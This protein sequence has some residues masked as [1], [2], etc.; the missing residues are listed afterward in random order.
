MKK[1][2]VPV[3]CIILFII[4]FFWLAPGQMDIGGDNSRLYFYDPLHYLQVQAL[5]AIIPS[6]VGGEAVSYWGIPYFLLLIVIKSIV[7]SPTLLIDI[8]HS[9]SLCMAFLA[10]YLIV[11]D[12]ILNSEFRKSKYGE[13]TAILSGLFY[14]LTPTLILG[15]DKQ[16]LTYNQIF[17]NP[18]MFFLLFRFI[19]RNKNKYLLLAL[20]VS[21]IFSPNFTFVAAPDFFAFYPIAIV[22]ILFYTKIILHRTIP[23]KK[24]LLGLLLFIAL[25]L[26]HLGPQ[27]SSLFTQGSSINSNVFSSVSKFSRGLDYFLGVAPYVKVSFSFLN[28]AQLNSLVPIDYTF[29][30]FPFIIFLGFL[31]N[32]GKQYL[33]T[34]IFFLITFFFVTGNIT[35]V[36]LDFYIKLFDI[37]GFSMFRNYFG[38]W[39]FVYTFFYTLLFGQALLMLFQRLKLRYVT[40]IT[41]IIIAII[42]YN[43]WPFLNGSL[44]NPVLYQSKNVKIVT[45]MDPEYE[46]VLSYIRNL[47][48][49]GKFIS[50][51][52]TDAGYQI[53]SGKNGGAYQGPS[54]IS[55]LTGKNDFTGYDGLDPFSDTFITLVQNNDINGID[56]LFSI[57]NIKYIFY[58]SDP[59]IYDN[60]FPQYPYTYVR[61]T[62]PED[63]KGYQAFLAKLPIHKVKDFGKYYHIYEVNNYLPHFYTTNDLIY[64]SD[65][66][67]PYYILDSLKSLRSVV[68]EQNETPA[69]TTDVI[70][71][72]TDVNPLLSLI[73]N[74]NLHTDYPFIS[75]RMDDIL[76]PF[77]LRKEKD[78]LAHLTDS[79]QDYV[80]YSLLYLSKR[81]SELETFTQTPVTH[82]PFFEPK[83]W[84]VY[85]RK[86][87]YSWEASLAHI[88]TQTDTL[89]NW[90]NSQPFSGSMKTT[91]KIIVDQ[92]LLGLQLRLRN[93][94]SNS[95]Y[96]E[97]DKSYLQK[98]IKNLFEGLYQKLD[99]QIVNPTQIPYTLAIPQSLV[100]QQFIPYLHSEKS[101]PLN[102]SEYSINIGNEKDSGIL[103]KS[104]SPLVTFKP[105]KITKQQ[106]DIVLNYKPINDVERTSWEGEG[107]I[108]QSLSQTILTIDDGISNGGG[109]S[110]KISNYQPGTQYLIT[111]DYYTQSGDAL[112]GLYEEQMQDNKFSSSTYFSDLLSSKTWKTQQAVITSSPYAT[113]AFI[114]FTA[115][116]SNYAGTLHIRNFSVIAVPNDTLLF[117][118]VIKNPSKQLPDIQFEKINPTRYLIHVTNAYNPYALV[119]SEQFNSDWKLYLPTSIPK[120]NSIVD[121]SFGG[122]V[123]QEKSEN[124]FFNLSF[125]NNGT[126]VNADSHLI[127]NGYANVWEISSQD[128]GNKS[129]YYLE[130]IYQPQV[131]FYYFAFVSVITFFGLLIFTFIIF[132]RKNEKK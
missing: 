25:Q 26:F 106:S 27:V 73:D 131:M 64:V 75:K 24:I 38:Q 49:D 79:P 81:I 46:N 68:Y 87:Y 102:P 40:V 113:S 77:V 57:L 84:Q 16:I 74:Y 132:L 34:A 89:I 123:K 85:K 69:I 13:L 56:R 112:F 111:F 51:P 20:F 41:F 104:K 126:L 100:G 2:V 21:F 120:Q 9:F 121:F 44:I 78:T 35:N 107:S 124:I 115:P 33:L 55:Y 32:R 61:G 53:L 122:S 4:P 14:I 86:E 117:R 98:Y 99:L 129:D 110:K 11:K 130:V 45:Q 114:Q 90:I 36:G 96:S 94:V 82:K 127:G 29:I 60:Y 58:N 108:E 95:N 37:P 31:W 118:K 93:L 103:S 91:E 8:S 119:F 7:H 62:M 71:S 70:L 92:S 39:V 28:L 50:F 19:T 18:F 12:L 17:L 63:Q 80:D 43:A 3:L 5:Y 1:F 42:G 88:Q 47:N 67:S 83:L 128:V 30:I 48:I 101:T 109:F 59:R 97:Y 54:T 23:I 52:L 65:V 105:I 66:L 125:L 116:D 10:T 22:F 6:G 72:A 76:Y 15:W